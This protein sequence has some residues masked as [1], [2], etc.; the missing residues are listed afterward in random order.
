MGEIISPFLVR[1]RPFRSD[2]PSQNTIAQSK[3][4]RKRKR[5]REGD[6]S[7]TN[8][9]EPAPKKRKKDKKDKLVEFEPHDQFAKSEPAPITEAPV[10]IAVTTTDDTNA[11]AFLAKHSIT[12]HTPSNLS[13]VIPVISFDKLRVPDPL[14]LVFKDFKEPTPI[15]ACTWPPALQGHDVV[16]I[17]ETGRYGHLNSA[18]TLHR[19][20]EQ[21]K[22]FSIW[23]TRPRSAHLR[24]SIQKVEIK[25]YARCIRPGGGAHP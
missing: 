12:I 17:A 24:A 16:G 1:P 18:P 22:D 25:I 11:S 21:W 23:H 10:Q 20:S 14:K 4:D 2:A 9:Q 19:S 5:R 3:K 13:P 8:V 15:Q 6:V 7:D